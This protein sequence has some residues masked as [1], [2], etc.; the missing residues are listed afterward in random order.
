MIGIQIVTHGN[1][2]S[3]YLHA[4]D[5]IIGE[6]SAVEINQLSPDQAID[7]FQSQ[8]LET[9]KKLLNNYDGVLVFVDMFGAS[10]FNVAVKNSQ[11]FDSDKYKVITGVSLPL[12]IEAYFSKEA[13]SL[14][15][16]YQN[17]LLIAKESVV[18]WEK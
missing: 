3:G 6:I 9:S 15:D 17:I 10:P 1:L 16:L 13:M 12:L 18:G 14:S 4:M 8:V 11:Y 2:A 7:A 5:M